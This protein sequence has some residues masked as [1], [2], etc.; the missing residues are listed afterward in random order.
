MWLTE[1]LSEVR[2]AIL[3]RGRVVSAG[4][5]TVV[6]ADMELRDPEQ[7]HPYGYYTKPPAGC[8]LICAEGKVLGSTVKGPRMLPGEVLIRSAGG[9]N[10]KLCNDGRVIINGK[11]FV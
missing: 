10:I 11:E 8:E 7:V 6:V 5:E 9:A 3:K 2:D 4:N 1:K